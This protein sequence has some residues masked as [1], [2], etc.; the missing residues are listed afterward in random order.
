MSVFPLDIPGFDIA[1]TRTINLPFSTLATVSGREFRSAW[2]G[3]PLY[4]YEVTFNFLRQDGPTEDEYAAIEGF[5]ESM[6][7]RFSSFVIQ[8]PKDGIFRLVRFDDDSMDTNRI[9]DRIW[10]AQSI[11]LT[12]IPTNGLPNPSFISSSPNDG[13]VFVPSAITYQASASTVGYPDADHIYTW[14][15]NDGTSLVGATVSKTWTGHGAKTATVT[16]TCTDTSTTATA[17]ITVNVVDTELTLNYMPQGHGSVATGSKVFLLGGDVDYSLC[18]IHTD[19]W[20]VFRHTESITQINYDQNWLQ[21]N[22]SVIDG[23]AVSSS[24]KYAIWTGGYGAGSPLV[25]NHLMIVDTEVGSPPSILQLPVVSPLDSNAQWGSEIASETF[26]NIKIWPTASDIFI[27][28]LNSNYGD[29]YYL[30]KIDPSIPAI[31]GTVYSATYPTPPSYPSALRNVVYDGENMYSIEFDVDPSKYR[32]LTYTFGSGLV[33]TSSYITGLSEDDYNRKFLAFSGQWFK[34]PGNKF[35]S[36]NHE[37]EVTSIPNGVPDILIFNPADFSI[38]AV[39]LTGFPSCYKRSLAGAAYA[40][41]G[42]KILICGGISFKNDGYDTAQITAKAVLFDTVSLTCQ[43][44][45][46]DMPA[47]RFNHSACNFQGLGVITGGSSSPGNPRT[48]NLDRAYNH[49]NIWFYDVVTNSFY[50]ALGL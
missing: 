11:K 20:T 1:V 36:I 7:G 4:N 31:T 14:S 26:D 24:G 12:G 40:V 28:N 15:F 9:V 37:V 35:Y 32:V 6:D 3:A 45:S 38:V 23:F 22:G 49:D 21:S 19:D 29:S 16:A 13:A 18:E 25:D 8:D 41:L 46:N 43:A 27:V 30:F 47:P 2:R 5:F 17:S 39:A 10:S 48:D 50:G 34:G 44:T 42:D 33:D